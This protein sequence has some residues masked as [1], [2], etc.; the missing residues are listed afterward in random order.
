MDRSAEQMRSLLAHVDAV[1]EKLGG[2]I[3]DPEAAVDASLV[4]EVARFLATGPS[5]EGVRE[6]LHLM[7]N[8]HLA[9]RSA[10]AV[11]DLRRVVE[12]LE[13]LTRKVRDPEE[14]RFVLGWVGRM[15]ATARRGGETGVGAPRS[16]SARRWEH[17]GGPQPQ[18]HLGPPSRGPMGGGPG[19]RRPGSG[20]G[21]FRPGGSGRGPSSGSGGPN[22]GGRR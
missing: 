17:Q 21:G 7:P 10:R 13:P 22:R 2:R 19:A 4:N 9:R 18:G 3:P 20:P 6:F 8:S 14:L 5:T 1:L 16:A 15:L 11:T 12:A